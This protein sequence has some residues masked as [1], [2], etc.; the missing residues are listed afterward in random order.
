M[1]MPIV[2]RCLVLVCMAMWD[3]HVTNMRVTLC[4]LYIWLCVYQCKAHCAVYYGMLGSAR[5][6]SVITFMLVCSKDLGNCLSVLVGLFG[7]SLQAQ[8]VSCLWQH[9]PVL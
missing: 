2:S 5:A 8:G 9:W 1:C 6:T 7:H 3:A 4:M